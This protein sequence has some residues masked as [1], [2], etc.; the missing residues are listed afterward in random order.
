MTVEVDK[1]LLTIPEVME[2]TGYSRSFVL[3]LLDKSDGLPTVRAGR[4]VRVRLDDL[5]LWIETQLSG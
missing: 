4:T 2:T 5:K 3:G 1:L